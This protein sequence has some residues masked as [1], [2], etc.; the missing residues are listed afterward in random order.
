M[1][2]TLRRLTAQDITPDL[3]EFY[4]KH[5][6]L[7][8]QPKR[9]ERYRDQSRSAKCFGAFSENGKIVGLI[10]TWSDKGEKTVRNL[11][12]ICVDSDYRNQG[13]ATQLF[14]SVDNELQGWL[15]HFRGTNPEVEKFFHKL[16][17]SGKR[18]VIP[19]YKNPL[20]DPS[21]RKKIEMRK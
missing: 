10:E 18:E 20:N 13:I 6:P 3:V 19:G 2:V 1:P 16:G 4:D 21:A 7:S 17:F 8:P 15:L 5:L 14:K 11:V 9:L 12:T